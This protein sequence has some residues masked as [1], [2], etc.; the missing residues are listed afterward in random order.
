MF[1]EMRFYLRN[2]DMV[3]VGTAGCYLF[4]D[5][6][7]AV[8]KLATDRAGRWSRLMQ[9]LI[10]PT[11]GDALLGQLSGSLQ[12]DPADLVPLLDRGL[13]LEAS[14]PDELESRRNRVFTDN[15]GYHL[16]QGEQK[17]EHL[18]VA[19][20]GSIT[21]GL[22]APVILSLC[23]SGFH[24]RIDLILTEA[25]LRF[26]NRDLFEFYGIRTWVNAFDRRDGI[27]VPHVALG[28]SADCL[29][30]M[31][32]SADCCRRIADGACTDLL[33]MTVTATTAPVV[34]APVMNTAMWNH[35]A[36]QRNV[37]QLRDD[38]M[39]VVDPTLIFAASELVQQGK[40]THGGAAGPG[41]FWRG[42]L[43]VMH[44]LS[45]VMEHRRQ[46]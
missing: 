1:N 13:L 36:V 39:Y 31:P 43:G 18:L 34:I 3:A 42:P 37:Q 6:N 12:I 30:V 5:S 28:Q 26:V 10:V 22:M 27:H 44:M 9:T 33:S 45:A 32:A 19:L 24:G 29:L 17:S 16:K 2:P 40:P 4:I 35:A 20:T 25:A 21:A 23:Y 8:Y 38:G 15:Q 41:T 14:T 11:R 7:G 46:R